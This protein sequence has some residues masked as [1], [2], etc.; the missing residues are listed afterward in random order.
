MADTT[1]SLDITTAGLSN[2]Q[3]L[4]NP[5]QFR[6]D[7]SAGLRYAGKG[8]KV[9]AAKEIGGRYVLTAA[10][11]KQDISTPKLTDDGIELRFARKAPTLRAYGGKPTGTTKAGRPI[12]L[13]FKI[14]KGKQQ[15]NPN[16][17]WL[18]VGGQPSPGLPFRRPPLGDKSYGYGVAYGPSI[19][20]IFGGKSAFG[21]VIREATT[22]RVQEHFIKGVQR[23]MA[24]RNRGF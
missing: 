4:L 8:A 13:A 12:G 16:V 3:A 9:T 1:V 2:M 17:F 21:E 18:N 22:Q 20:S 7:V 14:F 11:I 6:K 24:R 19:G 5:A 10:R 23:A 15:K